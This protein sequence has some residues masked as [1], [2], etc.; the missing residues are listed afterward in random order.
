VVNF[1]LN[2]FEDQ[3]EIIDFKLPVK[4]RPGLTKWGEKIFKEKVKLSKRVYPQD[5]NTEGFFLA[6]F[7]RI[8]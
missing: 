2:E 6:K 4:T 7:R 5:N 8:K 3:I 1:I